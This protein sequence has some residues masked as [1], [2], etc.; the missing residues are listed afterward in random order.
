MTHE[1]LDHV[2]GLPY[3]S[4]PRHALDLGPSWITA[5]AETRYYERLPNAKKKKLGRR[6]NV[7]IASGYL[8]A[9]APEASTPLQRLLLN[10]NPRSPEDC[11]KHL[12][13]RA[14]EKTY[15]RRGNDLGTGIRSR[16]EAR[17]LGPRGRHVLLLRLVPADGARPDRQ[18]FA[19]RDGGGRCRLRPPLSASTRGVLP[20]G[21]LPRPRVRDN[22]LAIDQAANNTSS[23]S[24]SSGG[25]GGSCSPATPNRGAGD[26]GQAW[27]APAVHLLK[28]AHHGS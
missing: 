8:E 17:D 13:R 24:R 5:S 21:R 26:N 4:R 12:R 25:A 9:S 6:G 19:G 15:V 1:H 23:S 14:A 27:P 16:G 20:P 18:Q 7:R 11:V 22:L 2:Q 10:N 3:A 28:V